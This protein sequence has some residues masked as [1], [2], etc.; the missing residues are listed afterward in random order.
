MVRF[1][2]QEVFQK[3]TCM[4]YVPYIEYLGFLLSWKRIRKRKSRLTIQIWGAVSGKD[5]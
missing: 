2:P 5:L 4:V 3:T 1:G